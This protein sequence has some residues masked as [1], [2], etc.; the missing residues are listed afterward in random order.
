[1]R[2]PDKWLPGES[3]RRGASDSRRAA[4]IGLLIILFLVIGGLFLTHILGGMTQVQDCSLSGR[5]NCGAQP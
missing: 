3:Q 4:L 5:S 2:N 1:M